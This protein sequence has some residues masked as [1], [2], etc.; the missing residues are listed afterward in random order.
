[1]LLEIFKILGNIVMLIMPIVLSYLILFFISKVIN[2]KKESTGQHFK[3]IFCLVITCAIIF[4]VLIVTLVNIYQV[5]MLWKEVEIEVYVEPYVKEA[6]FFAVEFIWQMIGVALIFLLWKYVYLHQ[7]IPG[8]GT[9]TERL[10]ATFKKIK[11]I[12]K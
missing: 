9:A 2:N 11:A 6:S 8:T 7:I 5:G 12:K 1:M 10:K 3:S 4:T